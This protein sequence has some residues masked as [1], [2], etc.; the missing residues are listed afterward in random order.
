[1]THSQWEFL[2]E[3][4]SVFLTNHFSFEIQTLNL[5][6]WF[7]VRH[8]HAAYNMTWWIAITATSLLHR[9][10]EF[11]R[12]ARLFWRLCVRLNE[13]NWCL[14]GW[15]GNSETAG[16][17]CRIGIKNFHWRVC[18]SE[19]SSLANHHWWF[20]IRISYILVNYQWWIYDPLDPEDLLREKKS[21]K[22]LQETSCKAFTT[23]FATKFSLK[24][25]IKTLFEKI[26]DL[27]SRFSLTR[28]V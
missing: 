27:H 28:T 15:R 17:V 26:G 8:L 4:F 13:R 2:T 25:F 24:F 16:P 1:M 23:Y 5:F 9:E 22:I 6:C 14:L 19:E 12:C 11:T 18:I 20:L 10:C 21:G 3:N 7:S